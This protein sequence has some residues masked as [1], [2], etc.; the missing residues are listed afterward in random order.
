VLTDSLGLEETWEYK[1]P[2]DADAAL[3]TGADLDIVGSPLEVESRKRR[4][5]ELYANA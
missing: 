4:Y 2:Q 1:T 5:D 3:S